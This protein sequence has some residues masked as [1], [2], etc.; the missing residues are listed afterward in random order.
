M[1]RPRLETG[2]DKLIDLVKDKKKIEI[3]EAARILGVPEEIILEL[4]RFL[5]EEAIIDIEYGLSKKYLKVRTV[6]KEQINQK[7][8]EVKVKK[9]E[10]KEKSEVML[11]KLERE[12][13]ELKNV[14]SEFQGLKNSLGNQV[15]DIQNKI[16]KI[17]EYEDADKKITQELF[18]KIKEYVNNIQVI[19]NEIR[20][21]ELTM[22]FLAD[23]YNVVFNE[24][25]ND[26]NAI[27]QVE[28]Q[29]Q[30]VVQSNVKQER[31]KR[32]HYIIALIK[33]RLKEGKNVDSFKKEL[34]SLG[35]TEDMINNS[36]RGVN[37]E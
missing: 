27:G 10:F 31:E 16:S 1:D 32:I 22:K 21:E 8:E 26:E 12:M 20:N 3:G 4:A 36:L 37:D 14:E 6:T 5:E 18:A 13:E 9:S 33:K 17:K 11:M 35:W 25:K 19:E 2:V 28:K 34:I 24:I 30:D 29:K 15:I 7:S 23:Q